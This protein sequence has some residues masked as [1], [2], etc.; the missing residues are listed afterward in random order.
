MAL[1]LGTLGLEAAAF[2]AI[3]PCELDAMLRGRFGG[4][5]APEAISRSKFMHLMQQFP[6]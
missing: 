4:A 2:W 6:D 3:T 5:L 1:G